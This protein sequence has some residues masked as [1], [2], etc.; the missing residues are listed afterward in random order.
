MS[1][2]KEAILGLA[3]EIQAQEDKFNLQFWGKS[4][5]RGNFVFE[6]EVGHQ[7]VVDIQ[8]NC[9]AVGCVAGWQNSIHN[10]KILDS[11]GIN[12]GAYTT[13]GKVNLPDEIVVQLRRLSDTAAA[14][15]D[16][17][18]TAGQAWELFTP[19]EEGRSIWTAYVEDEYND[20]SDPYTA[21][22]AQAVNLLRDLANGK[23]NFVDDPIREET[24]AS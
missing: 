21:T 4:G 18:L 10:G 23:A 16:L 11:L 3:D 19:D 2:N 6:T 7:A 22:G 1:I 20:G 9:G 13:D 15:D 14:A 17:G 5:D 12:L 8:H 24:V